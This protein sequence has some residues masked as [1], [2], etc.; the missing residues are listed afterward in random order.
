MRAAIFPAILFLSAMPCRAA[1][2]AGEWTVSSPVWALQHVCTFRHTGSAL[3]GSCTGPR[4][5][6]AVRGN[7]SGPGMRFGWQAARFTD[8][9]VNQWIFAGRMEGDVI[10]GTLVRGR[11]HSTFV[12]R[13]PQAVS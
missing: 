6:G 12:A 8:K 1:D 3:A 13:R 11:L 10:R 9:A 7:I 2:I 4:A 5:Q